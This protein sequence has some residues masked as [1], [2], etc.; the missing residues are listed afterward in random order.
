L[1]S[2]DTLFFAFVADIRPEAIDETRKAG[3]RFGFAHQGQY[4]LPRSRFQSTQEQ[5]PFKILF[6]CGGQTAR[7]IAEEIFTPLLGN[8]ESKSNTQQ[9]EQL[10]QRLKNLQPRHIVVWRL[11]DKLRLLKTTA[12]PNPKVNQAQLAEVKV[13][14]L[15]LRGIVIHTHTDGQLRGKWNLHKTKRED[16]SFLG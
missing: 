6:G 11:G 10:V 4:Q 2:R 12:V 1:L 9:R 3:L 13:E 14:L 16:T 5:T 15:Q 8:K 7:S